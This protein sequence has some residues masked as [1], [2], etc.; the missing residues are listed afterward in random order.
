MSTRWV[1]TPFPL[2]TAWKR[3]GFSLP[4]K[5]LLGKYKY[6]ISP[7]SWKWPRAQLPVFTWTP[8]EHRDKIS[9]ALSLWNNECTVSLACGL[10]KGGVR[11]SLNIAT[12]T[13]WLWG[14]AALG[15]R[16]LMHKF[17]RELGRSKNTGPSQDS[18]LCVF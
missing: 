13:L 12:D 1:G 8:P 16:L 4:C 14:E 3:H 6:L 17:P 7:G 5:V 2:S 11:A 9:R 10:Q 15:P 18:M